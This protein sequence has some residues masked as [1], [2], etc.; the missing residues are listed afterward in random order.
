M[1]LRIFA[2]N[3]VDSATLTSADFLTALPASNL[4]LEGRVRVARTANATGLKTINGD[5]SGSTVCSACVLYA[6]NLTA[7]CTM[8]LRLYDGA[9]QTG[10]VV[11]DSGTYSPIPAT[12]WGDFSWGTEPWGGAL[13]AN[14]ERP[15]IAL[16]M[17]GVQALS[18][19]LEL[20]DTGNPSGYIQAKRLFL[21]SYFEPT[22]NVSY[23]MELTW[24]DNSEQRRT[25]GGSIRTQAQ[26]RYRML[27]GR[28]GR[29][30]ESERAAFMD[31][32]RTAALRSE[33]FVTVFPGEG[34][35]RERDYSLLGKFT[36][37]PGVSHNQPDNW[38]G[39]FQ[40]EEV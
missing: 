7:S 31:A 36:R 35:A 22:V 10:T 21:G 1:S 30:D 28:L 39:E 16:Y 12:G 8:R 20:T 2:K 4:S 5:F 3:A 11:Y 14:W 26:N 27:T 6:H 29:L 24:M 18:F 9:A 34:G 32:L 37:M 33:V 19:K 23:G 25:Q 15:F 38:T 17:T 40:V 13:F